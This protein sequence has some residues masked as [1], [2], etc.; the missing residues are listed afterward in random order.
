MSFK[1]EISRGTVENFL[2][3]IPELSHV[4]VRARGNVLILES[5]EEDGTSYPRAR[6][7]QK[8]ACKWDLEMPTRR[9]WESTF[10]E[11]TP[12]ELMEVLVE[13]FPWTLAD[14]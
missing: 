12:K 4:K 10:I 11:G 2:V 6:L 1:A 5:I 3:A 8:S 9:G 13:K 14:Q 7:K